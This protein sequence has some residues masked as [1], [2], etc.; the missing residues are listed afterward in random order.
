MCVVG[1]EDC[2]Y[3]EHCWY[4]ECVLTLGSVSFESIEV[5]LVL[6]VGLELTYVLRL[7]VFAHMALIVR[8]CVHMVLILGEHICVGIR[9]VCVC[10]IRNVCNGTV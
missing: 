5:L 3:R 2:G 8:V 4:W 6:G 7:K 10:G 9:S 1:V